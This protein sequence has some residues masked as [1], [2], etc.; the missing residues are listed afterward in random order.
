MT[1]GRSDAT[2]LRSAKAVSGHCLL[3]ANRQ[4]RGRRGV[5]DLARV[6]AERAPDYARIDIRL[7]RTVTVGGRPLNLSFGV[8]NVTNRRNFASYS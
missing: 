3:A 8:Q 7:D 1:Y 5:Y 2:K 6:N 4:Q